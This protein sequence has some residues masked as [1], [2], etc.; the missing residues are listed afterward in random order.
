MDNEEGYD[1]TL[2]LGV[3]GSWMTF[4]V[5]RDELIAT[6]MAVMKARDVLAYGWYV[7]GV[8]VSKQRRHES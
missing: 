5:A 7:D 1:V 4:V 3:R 8:K 2:N 6:A